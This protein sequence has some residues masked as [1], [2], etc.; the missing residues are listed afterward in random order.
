MIEGSEL[1]ILH[2]GKYKLPIWKKNQKKE[3]PFYEKQNKIQQSRK[4]QVRRV[5]AEIGTLVHCWWNIK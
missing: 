5:C 2:L 3:N 4:W 1:E